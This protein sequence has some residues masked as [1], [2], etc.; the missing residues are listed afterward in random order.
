MYEYSKRGILCF[1]Y[2]AV[3][4]YSKLVVLLRFMYNAVYED[5]NREEF[6]VLYI[7]LCMRTAN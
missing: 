5:S 3:Y 4:E 7:M 1:I 2:N 6:Y